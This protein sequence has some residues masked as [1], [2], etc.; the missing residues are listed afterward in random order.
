M[1]TG[2]GA[3]CPLGARFC[4]CS[5]QPYQ[6]HGKLSFSVSTVPEALELIKPPKPSFWRTL[7]RSVSSSLLFSSA[8]AASVGGRSEAGDADA[9]AGA[10]PCTAHDL[11]LPAALGSA[12][13]AKL[14][15]RV[16]LRDGQNL[17]HY[18]IPEDVVVLESKLPSFVWLTT[19]ATCE[20][21]LPSLWHALTCEHAAEAC[22]KTSACV[23]QW[24]APVGRL[25][26]AFK[27]S[28]R[29][30]LLDALIELSIKGSVCLVPTHLLSLPGSN[31]VRAVAAEDRQK[32]D[33]LSFFSLVESMGLFV[34]SLCT[35]C[36]R[37]IWYCWRMDSTNGRCRLCACEET[38]ATGT[39][40]SHFSALP[41]LCE[42][43][44]HTSASAVS[45]KVWK[46]QPVESS[47]G[48][49]LVE[50]DPIIQAIDTPPSQLSTPR[51][52]S[53]S[54]PLN[55]RPVYPSSV[56]EAEVAMT[57]S[58][59]SLREREMS[60]RG[61]LFASS[62]GGLFPAKLI[63]LAMCE[64]N[65]FSPETTNASAANQSC[66]LGVNASVK[67]IC[68]SNLDQSLFSSPRLPAAAF[69]S[70]TLANAVWPAAK[71]P[72]EVRDLGVD[73][74]QT[75]S[76]PNQVPVQG[77]VASH[78][79][80]VSSQEAD[81]AVT[82][83]TPQH[84]VVMP[85][86]TPGAL[87]VAVVEDE[88]FS[89]FTTQTLNI[90]QNDRETETETATRAKNL[91]AAEEVATHLKVTSTETPTTRDS[92]A[93]SPPVVSMGDAR[94]GKPQPET[95][96][97]RGGKPETASPSVSET[98][99]DPAAPPAKPE[100]DNKSET[101]SQYAKT[102]MCLQFRLGQ[103]KRGAENC[104]FAHSLLEL[105]AT[106][107]V[108]KTKLCAFWMVG[109]CKAGPACRHAHGEEELRSRTSSNHFPGTEKGQKW[110]HRQQ[111]AKAFR[112]ETNDTPLMSL[113][114]PQHL[115]SYLPVD[116]LSPMG[117]AHAYSETPPFHMV[118]SERVAEG[119]SQKYGISSGLIVWGV[120][121]Q[122]RVSQQLVWLNVNPSPSTSALS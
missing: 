12:Y 83:T 61:L 76:L 91:E 97:L 78:T 82:D 111:A 65:E 58:V 2:G 44:P 21:Y 96:S 42:N 73:E 18:R 23:F 33:S 17:A 15:A 36:N 77:G 115:R 108:Y 60:G 71:V 48:V 81:C 50:Q 34:P 74:A 105:R 8:V 88:P 39:D 70:D 4:R 89:D 57:Q 110:R 55:M 84:T 14:F 113:H 67:T 94:Q 24:F 112:N 93:L 59:V 92:D 20:K 56:L 6:F 5:T 29:F 41:S 118:G 66:C 49:V 53:N 114:T 121:V 80:T 102:R 85:L 3:K 120:P 63:K 19:T 27:E 11:H 117:D 45:G 68:L 107:D 1:T 54:K 101:T 69:A 28:R 10:S 26:L 16:C 51:P 62:P 75:R 37:Y 87:H 25:R 31:N 98:S 40:V 122:T 116:G 46:V 30:F 22:C 32:Q 90:A 100:E 103:C 38:L 64:T 99:T 104:K 86:A 119:L 13:V 106:Q 43:A 47:K 9:S 95:A 35:Y 7:S 109:N 52:A 79:V 72:R